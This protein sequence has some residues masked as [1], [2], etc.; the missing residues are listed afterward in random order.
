M[1]RS[2][3]VDAFRRRG[4]VVLV[5]LGGLLLLAASPVAAE[6]DEK[7]TNVVAFPNSP[8]MITLTWSH[9]GEDVFWF[10]LEQEAPA[11]VLQVDQD[12]R[13]WSVPNLEPSRT[14][15]YRV[16]AVFAYSRKCS[17]EDGVG[18]ASVTTLP[19]PPS[20]GG[21][22]GGAPPPPAAPQTV[23]KPLYSPTIRALP[24]RIGPGTAPLVQLRWVNP[25]DPQ[26]FA[27]LKT[28]EWHRDGA[29][30]GKTPIP[31]F[32][33][34][35]QPN[36]VHRY[37][38]C[39]ENP[40]N[41]ICSEE[42]V[43]GSFGLAAS[44]ESLNR[45]KHFIRHR[46]WLGVLTPV[47]S[48]QDSGDIAFFM[49]PG[50]TG[51]ART[52]SFEA[53]NFPKHFLRHQA[54]RMKLHRNDDADLFRKDATFWVRPGLRNLPDMMSF[55]AVNVPGHFIRHQNFELWIARNDGSNLFQE[56][57]TF[58][59]ATDY[60]SH[61]KPPV[62]VQSTPKALT[63]RSAQRSAAL[64]AAATCKSGYV[65]REARSSDLV[66][67]TPASRTKVAEENRTTAQGVQPGAA[68]TCRSGLVWREAFSG[69]VVCVPP[70]RRAEVREENRVG[71]S[72]RAR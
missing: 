37:K 3:P 16:C 4:A 52:V 46:N 48:N 64:R 41:R 56:D 68:P 21:S 39:V 60:V 7:P 65:W 15:R 49:R 25:V 18:F 32:E 33:D 54:Y 30:I 57:A 19:R 45:R 5:A 42:V 66:C 58:R 69:D 72:L 40:V 50:L 23:P 27:L 70:G 44:F 12:K 31:A 8:G 20:G 22:A 62:P 9:S 67:V 55:E 47:A 59:Q 10:I 51:D 61:L 35:Q 38:V 63:T 53:V 43:A 1:D 34:A 11:A 26:Q 2:S 28:I 36:A 17:D 29:L 6:E 24:V 14:Y 71:A 13:T